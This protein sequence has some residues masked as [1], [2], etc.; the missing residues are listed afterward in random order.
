MSYNEDHRRN[1]DTLEHATSVMRNHMRHYHDEPQSKPT[2]KD[3]NHY[4]DAIEDATAEVEH[5]LRH[6]RVG[7]VFI[8]FGGLIL[9]AGIS[10]GFFGVLFG[11]AAFW[12][13]VLCVVLGLGVG[14]FGTAWADGPGEVGLSKRRLVQ[15]ERAMR[16][17]HLK[18]GDES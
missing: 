7:M 5:D 17:F 14:V 1:Y 8:V 10:I 11:F 18:G 9:L 2:P 16:D 13:T 3:W 6:L 12:L 15:A 4:N